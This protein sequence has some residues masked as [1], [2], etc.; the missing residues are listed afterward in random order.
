MAIADQDE[1]INE[2]IKDKEL[3]IITGENYL[4]AIDN[5]DLIFKSPGISL[6]H[7]KYCV[8]REKITSQTDIFL[9]YYF[10]QIIG[11]TGTKGKSTTSSLIY[12][13]IK[14]CTDNVTLVGNIGIPPFDVVEEI[15][16]DTII[17]YELSSHQLEYISRGPKTGILLNLF[18]EHLDHY[19]SFEAY[20]HSKFNL[21][22]FQD[23]TDNFIYN[24]DDRLITDLLVENI[25]ER[26]YFKYSLQQPQSKGCWV[27]NERIYFSDGK[28]YTVLFDLNTKRFLN[29]EHNIK[30]IM[31]AMCACKTFDIPDDK[32][33]EGI[34]TFKGLEHR[35]EYV[36]EYEGI[37]YYNDSIAT[38]PEATI[39]AIKT[40]INVETIIF[41]GFDRG[42]DYNPLLAF[43]IESSVKNLILLGDAGSRMME[44]LKN[45]N[46]VNKN[47]FLVNTFED[48]VKMA[49]YHTAPSGICLLSPAAAS[50]DMFKNFE[51][52]G[53]VFKKLVS[54][55]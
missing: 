4:N 54:D 11:V 36:G 53:R 19:T 42:I 13:I 25:L 10:R 37:K 24:A 33:I 34:I 45:L 9:D 8:P 5:F 17:V 55:H 48:A 38:I 15:S 29:G 31:A 20:K 26:N 27:Q 41:G 14:L 46:A 39:E 3:T 16:N 49:K 52:R 43:L 23:A 2:K 50:Y 44:G 18:Q 7:L 22:L 30:N 35:I 1:S 28:S 6:N 40:L 21:T 32:I 47:I 12:S 51:E